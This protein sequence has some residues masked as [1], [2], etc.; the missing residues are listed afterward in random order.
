M[1]IATRPGETIQ[2]RND[3]F[4]EWLFRAE[5]MDPSEDPEKW[6]AEKNY[7]REASNRHMG[8]DLVDASALQ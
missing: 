4:V 3:Q 2:A 8:A 5:V 6:Q 7:L 1:Q